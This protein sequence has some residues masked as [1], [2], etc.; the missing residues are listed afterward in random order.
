MLK[1]YDYELQSTGCYKPIGIFYLTGI[2][3][4]TV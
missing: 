4:K 3:V 1:M 2:G